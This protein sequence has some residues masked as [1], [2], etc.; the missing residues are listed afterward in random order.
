MSEGSTPNNDSNSTVNVTINKADLLKKLNTYRKLHEI[1]FENALKLWQSSLK[2]AIAKIQAHSQRTYPAEL[3][4]LQENCPVSY[5]E[6]YDRA[7]TMFSMSV[8]SEITLDRQEF[9][10]YCCDDWDWRAEI[11]SNEYWKLAREKRIVEKESPHMSVTTASII[12]N[13]L[14]SG[15][16]VPFR[17]KLI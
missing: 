15:A 16:T 3:S 13:S 11:D 2:S 14:N 10:R 5:I 1:D 7:I 9:N 8:S 4:E 17:Q 6:D 12:S